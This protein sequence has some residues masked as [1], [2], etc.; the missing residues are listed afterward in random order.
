MIPFNWSFAV[1]LLLAL[2]P[3]GA[4][5]FGLNYPFRLSSTPL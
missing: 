3:V 4:G 5:A 2:I 1:E